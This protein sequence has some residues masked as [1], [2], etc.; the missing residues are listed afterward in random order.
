[1]RLRLERIGIAH[2]VA[3]DVAA[4]RDGVQQRWSIA[5]SVVFRFDLMTP[6][7]LHGLPRGQPHRAVAV[8]A[9]DAVERK[10]LLRRQHAA[11]DA[12]PQHEGERLLQ[13]LAAAL[14]A[15]VAVVLQIHAVE[16]DELLVVLGDRA[17]DLLAQSFGQA[18][19]AGSRSLP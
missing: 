17:G 15:E 14:G 3:V 2:H 18:C 13:L 11:G 6:C 12:H 8:I 9:R 10:P 1:M 19:R 16:L 5:F 4:G 7:K